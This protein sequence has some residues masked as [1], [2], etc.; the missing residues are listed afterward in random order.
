SKD[1]ILGSVF[2]RTHGSTLAD[3]RWLGLP[4]TW[5][6]YAAYALGLAAALLTAIYMTRMM[7]YTFHGP[8]RTGENERGYLHEAPWIM[9]A[10]LLVLGV[11]SAFGGWLNLPALT[12]FLGPVGA[13]DRWLEPVVGESTLRVTNG[14][15]PEAAHNTELALVGS[16]VAIAVVGILIAVLRL[17]PAR[18]VPKAQAPEEEG[19]ERVLVNKYYVDEGYDRVVVRPTVGISRGVL[20]KGIDQGIIDNLFVNGSAKVARA[21]GAFGSWMQTGQVG[22]YAWVLVIGV[23]AV[24]GA[25]TI[26]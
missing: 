6:L 18:L 2:L 4:G 16:A 21:F 5:I 24:I 23:L 8:N 19:F 17:R 7:L 22:T 20:W 12:S 14:V 13:L 9:T 25:F 15:A 11:L 1:E 26:R 10:P 3:A